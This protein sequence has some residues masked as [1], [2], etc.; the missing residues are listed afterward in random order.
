M[1]LV[2][3][4]IKICG[5]TRLADAR[6]ALELGADLLGFNFYPASPRYL[7]P[8]AAGKIVHTLNCSAAAV[9]VFVNAPLE[10]MAA[11][12][13]QCPLRALQLHGDESHQNWHAATK[14]GVEVIPAVRVRSFEDI[15][16]A[17]QLP[18]ETILLDAFSEKL[19][20]GT[21]QRFDWNFL[22]RLPGKKV[23]LAGGITPQN[24]PEALA[25]QT[26]GIDICSGVES[27]PGV[28]DERKL[29]ALF[30]QV[31]DFYGP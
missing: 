15:E 6:L 9:G 28:K 11:V 24:V 31:K 5:I 27:T 30:E 21:G 10:T 13:Q 7:E 12:L 22:R 19:Y 29:R 4:K 2:R 17:M 26:Y 16:R 23:F 1:E 14:L 25:A 20:G 8:A 18:A 3:A